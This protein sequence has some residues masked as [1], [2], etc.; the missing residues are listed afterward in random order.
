V[1]DASGPAGINWALNH[2]QSVSGVVALNTVYSLQPDAPSK[3]PEAIR[4]FSD[5]NY[6][7]LTAY[8]A[9]SPREFR[10]CLYDFQVGGFI[11]NS[12]VREKFVPLL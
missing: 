2:P 5:T 8:F 12:D 11:L 1:H 9:K 3:P 7:R 4:L 6:A 10:C